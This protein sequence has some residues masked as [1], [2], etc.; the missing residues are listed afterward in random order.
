VEPR[1]Y[2]HLKTLNTIDIPEKKET[3]K[4]ATPESFGLLVSLGFG[5]AAFTPATYQRRRLQRPS[6]EIS[7]RDELRA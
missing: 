2:S 7:S 3:N 1:G 4:K 6:K 5:V